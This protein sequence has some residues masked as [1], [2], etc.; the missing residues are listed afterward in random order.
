MNF[1]R[2]F[3]AAL[4]G[5]AM[6]AIATI[7]AAFSLDGIPALL[8][9]APFPKWQQLLYRWSW[10]LIGV[11]TYLSL[12]ALFAY[13]PKEKVKFTAALILMSIFGIIGTSIWKELL[14]NQNSKIATDLNEHLTH[15]L[16][17]LIPPP[18]VACLLIFGI[19]HQASMNDQEKSLNRP[20]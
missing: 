7:L 14:P 10:P 1:K 12:T 17:L 9:D 13:T 11:T 16:I 19:H 2:G 20:D 3:V 18:I 8:G 6:A 4:L 5:G 15:G